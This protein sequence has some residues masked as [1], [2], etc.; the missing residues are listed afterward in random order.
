MFPSQHLVVAGG[1]CTGKT[2]LTSLLAGTIQGAIAFP[3]HK[4]LF[5]SQF[6]RDPSFAFMN[7][8][9]YTVQIL[10]RAPAIL[11]HNGAV[12]EDR[13]IFDTHEVF[14]AMMVENGLMTRQQY[15]VLTRLYDT[16]RQL[17]RP[18]LLI[19]L[20]CSPDVSFQRMSMRDDQEEK[21]VSVEYLSRLQAAYLSWYARFK[22]CRKTRVQT[23]T[24][25]VP[26]VLRQVVFQM[27]SVHDQHV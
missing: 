19:F 1:I 10:E 8:L 26:D 15:D 20:D 3:E 11:R 17:I 4:G 12:I 25:Q 2:T 22:L 13:S 21:P 6:Y 18:T 23:D 9:D 16:G 24:L 27:E 5:L 7:Q 14:S